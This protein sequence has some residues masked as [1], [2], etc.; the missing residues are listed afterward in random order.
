[1]HILACLFFPELNLCILRLSALYVRQAEGQLIPIMK[2]TSLIELPRNPSIFRLVVHKIP[3]NSSIFSWAFHKAGQKCQHF[4]F[5]GSQNPGNSCMLAHKYPG[6][7]SIVSLVFHKTDPEMPAL[8]QVLPGWHSGI[9]YATISAPMDKAPSRA[10][11]PRGQIRKEAPAHSE[12]LGQNLTPKT[13]QKFD[14]H[15]G[16]KD[17][18]PSVY[19]RRTLLGN[20]VCFLCLRK[21]KSR[22][23]TIALPSKNYLTQICRELIR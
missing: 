16:Q 15:W 9:L 12:F 10:L 22:G 19:F 7:S 21:R 1:M 18:L 2:H 14:H 11:V 23:I 5:G 3:R 20:F 4:R 13:R 8:L 6:N 17:H